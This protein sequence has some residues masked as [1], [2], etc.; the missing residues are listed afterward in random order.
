[1]MVLAG[2]CINNL[3]D[4]V[5]TLHPLILTSYQLICL[6][7]TTASFVYILLILYNCCWHIYAQ[8]DYFVKKIFQSCIEIFVELI[9]VHRQSDL[10]LI[11]LFDEA[12]FDKLAKSSLSLLNSLSHPL[13]GP[14]VAVNVYSHKHGVE[15]YNN[16][17]SREMEGDP[18]TMV[19]YKSSDSGEHTNSSKTC[20][21]HILTR[22]FTTKE[23][24]VEITRN[25]A[26][27]PL[28]HP[29]AQK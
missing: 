28:G 7:K 24:T 2:P 12:R 14:T 9:T 19:T 6:S 11:E 20:S 8:S 17:K 26:H 27:D 16:V 23:S 18:V 22:N 10:K 25:Y 5:S 1:M 4:D 15:V 29:S 21:K 13:D 3:F